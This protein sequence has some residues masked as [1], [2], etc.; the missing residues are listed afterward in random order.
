MFMFA[1]S[2]PSPVAVG[3]WQPVFS[4][5]ITIWPVIFVPYY[6]IN[7]H[8]N[9][10]ITIVILFGLLVIYHMVSYIPC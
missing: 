7:Y 8:I 6:H 10:H 1:I 3:L 2:K 9:Y 4:T 5:L